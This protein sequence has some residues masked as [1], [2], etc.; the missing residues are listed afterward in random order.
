MSIHATC[1]MDA[2]PY[3][4]VDLP[5]TKHGHLLN[6]LATTVTLCKGWQ[7]DSNIR[8]PI[9][10]RATKPELPNKSIPTDA[11]AAGV[12]LRYRSPWCRLCHILPYSCTWRGSSNG[13]SPDRFKTAFGHL[14]EAGERMLRCHGHVL[15]PQADAQKR[16]PNAIFP[17]C[18]RRVGV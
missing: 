10:A 17:V 7:S 9:P 3:H 2:H 14:T 16:V 6:L 1:G 8:G 5:P 15:I 13:C 12:G 18:L 11:F 4:I